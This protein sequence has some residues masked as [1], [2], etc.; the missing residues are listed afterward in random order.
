[1]SRVLVRA[2]VRS[3]PARRPAETPTP[4]ARLEDSEPPPVAQQ[5]LPAAP[6]VKLSAPEAAVRAIQELIRRDG[7]RP[8]A[9]LPSQRELSSR[10]N[11]SRA[12]LREA[13]STLEAL[14]LIQTAAGRGTFV[15][16]TAANEEEAISA[17]RF[18]ERY[19]L[20]EVY[21]FRYLV[22]SAAVRLAA[23]H[24]T[25]DELNELRLLHDQF[26][27]KLKASDFMASAAYDYRFHRSIMVCSR[28]RMFVDIY[29]KFHKVF[30][31]TQMLPFARK[32]RRW[33]AVVEHGKILEALQ[34]HDPDGAAFFLEMHL[35]RATERIGV[36]LNLPR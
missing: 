18:S 15:T 13:L 29:D 4:H 30:Q 2:P 22:E 26:K 32:P 11:V 1:M 34:Q 10:L 21:E 28:N 17:W 7:L 8:G 14:R 6:A 20:R 9:R 5:F 35:L 33:E 24:V 36:K 16:D 31:Q 3:K 27:A 19:E 23:I 25:D 12:S